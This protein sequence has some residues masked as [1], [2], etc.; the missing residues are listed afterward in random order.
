MNTI[1]N[2]QLEKTLDDIA[3][4]KKIIN[5]NKPIFLQVFNFTNFRRTFL[6]FGIGVLVVSMLFYYL[7]GYYGGH[8]AIPDKTKYLIIIAFIIYFIFIQI[9]EYRVWVNS[10]KNIGKIFTYRNLNK[11]LLSDR[12]KH[13]FFSS[14]YLTILLCMFFLIKGIPYFI[15][16]TLA[17]YM[18][19][20]YLMVAL[21]YIKYSLV[22]GYWYLITGV[23]F[24]IFNIIPIEIA[25]TISFGVGNIFF[26]VLGYIN[27][28]SNKA[29]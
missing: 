3:S 28:K 13:P 19:L 11:E 2:D 22:M 8:E 27:H 4:I 16:P 24:L 15:I 7:K 20:F 10:Y 25:T 9:L 5:R 12:Y 26:G 18:G 29:E 17:I 1:D 23:V 21:F 14:L 6:L